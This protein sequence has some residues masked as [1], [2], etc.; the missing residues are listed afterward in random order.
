MVEEHFLAV[1]FALEYQLMRA[2]NQ[3][4]EDMSKSDWSTKFFHYVFY[5]VK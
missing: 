4:M 2:E 5:I 3:A 1:L